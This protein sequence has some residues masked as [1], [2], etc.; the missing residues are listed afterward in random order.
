MG[1]GRDTAATIQIQTVMAYAITMRAATVMD[2]A[3]AV[4]DTVMAA[5][6]TAADIMADAVGK[7]AL[8]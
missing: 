5:D 7:E 1:Q 4:M 3:T 6:I 8:F 2:T